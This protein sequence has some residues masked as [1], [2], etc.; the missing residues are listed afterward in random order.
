[1][2]GQRRTGLSLFEALIALALLALLAGTLGRAMGLGLRLWDRTSAAETA[3]DP[4]GARVQL[5]RVLTRALPP[6]RIV[7][8]ASDFAGSADG[9]AFTTLSTRTLAPNAAALRVTVRSED[10]RLT[11]DIAALDDTGSATPVLSTTLATGL[12]GLRLS[13]GVPPAAGV[14]RS[15][16]TA[17]VDPAH[18]RSGRHTRLA[19]FRRGVAAWPIDRRA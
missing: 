7:P 6:N 13:Y 9:F 14:D 2:T 5:R 4:L 19:G 8:F 16:A 3:L 1:M 10:G 17:A 15:G 11:M 18:R 12:T